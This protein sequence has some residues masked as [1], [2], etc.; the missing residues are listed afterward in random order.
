MK[1]FE[2]DL[3]YIQAGVAELEDYL[4]SN[5]IFWPIDV[6]P[7][8]GEPGYPQLTLG[9]L[10]LSR[11]RLNCYNKSPKQIVQVEKLISDMDAIRSRWKVAWE[12][13]ATHGFSVR[14]K[15]WRDYIEEYRQLPQDNADRYPYEARLRTMLSLLQPELG[16]QS[17][18]EIDLLSILDNYLDNV[19]ITGSFIWEP[20]LQPGF[21]EHI[22][23]YLYGRLPAMPLKD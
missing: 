18:A 21:P 4:L 20:E 1:S 9:G 17:S 23:W 16:P 3:R 10:L 7:P 11:E 19:L 5:E 12:N 13:K 8:A 15:M 14:I 6:R 22:Y 2:Y